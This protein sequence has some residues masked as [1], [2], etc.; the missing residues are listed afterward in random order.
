MLLGAVPPGASGDVTY[1]VLLFFYSV[2]FD[3][4]HGV[5]FD[6]AHGVLVSTQDRVGRLCIVSQRLCCRLFPQHRLL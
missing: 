4:A 5:P 6:G 2:P 1:N 3:G